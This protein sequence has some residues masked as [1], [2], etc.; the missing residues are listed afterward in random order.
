MGTNL[1]ALIIIQ[2]LTSVVHQRNVLMQMGK[3]FEDQTYH[4][5]LTG[6]YNRR[7]LSGH[8]EKLISWSR[9]NNAEIGC[10]MM[11]IDHFKKINDEFG[12]EKGDEVIVFFIQ[13][14]RKVVRPSDVLI[15]YGGEEFL[16]LIPNATQ[17]MM[18]A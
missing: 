13:M 15:R 10:V 12:H 11:D 9:C 17:E 16:L 18:I 2:D 14:L 8:F 5:P 6:V 1:F 3:K 4:D 7:F